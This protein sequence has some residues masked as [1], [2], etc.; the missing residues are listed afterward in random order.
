MTT[1]LVLGASGFIGG[2]IASAALEH[3]WHVRG[4]RRRPLATG[5]LDDA[6]VDWY[7]GNLD[8]P[9]TL[10][11][12]FQGADIVLHA[13]AYY[14]KNS[15]N[16]P[17]QVAQA[18]HQARAV[19]D[20]CR[21]AGAA[22]LVFISSLTTIGRPPAGEARLADERDH[23]TPGSLPQSAY[24]ECKYA[25]ES[26]VLRASA[27]LPVVVL[28]PTAV[29]GPGDVHLTLGRILLAIARGYGVA[30][31]AAEANAVDVRDVAAAAIQAAEV[32]GVGERYILGGHNLPVRDLMSLAAEAAGVP[33]PRFEIPLWTIDVVV[34]LG[35]MLPL[36]D[37]AG[38]H[39][40]AVRQWQGY[41][42]SK[43]A[44][45]LGLRPRPLADT[46]GEALDW[47]TAHGFQAPR[48]LVV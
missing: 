2:H 44:R 35:K 20:Q 13:A 1:A 4:L 25:M 17:G 45:E 41:D 16:I 39:L 21:A 27:G 29:F 47:F 48:S 6:P 11:P 12:A 34:A 33:P 5:H 31:I 3:G 23:Y 14:P 30:W 8:Q 46:L 15:R 22:R 7:E 40:R 19:L 43:A 36:L 32:G 38:N 28:N 26:E 18:V 37:V 24:Y 42:S 9:A 10:S